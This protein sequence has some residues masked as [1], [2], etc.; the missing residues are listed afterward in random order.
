MILWPLHD[1]L[2]PFKV[3]PHICIHKLYSG[4]FACYFS[5]GA[6]VDMDVSTR[7]RTQESWL[8]LSLLGQEWNKP[9]MLFP[10]KDCVRVFLLSMEWLLLWTVFG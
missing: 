4:F 10:L 6:S 3:G 1:A 5:L 9:W 8:E 2:L 7:T